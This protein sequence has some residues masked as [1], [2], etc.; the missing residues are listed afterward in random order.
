VKVIF[1]SKNFLVQTL[2][3]V[4]E[5]RPHISRE[6]GGH[7]IISPKVKVADRQHLTARQAIE[8][9]RLTVVVGEAMTTTMN[10]LGIDI[11]RINY[12][13][14]GNW[15]VLK[16]EGAFLHIHLYGRAKSARTQIYGEALSFPKP[17]TGFY[18]N[19]EAFSDE[20]IADLK[21]EIESLS[22]LAKYSDTAWRLE[23]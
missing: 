20:D 14:N 9:M 23:Q 3:G 6:D 21:G 17:D 5:N 8:L 4:N 16:P 10:R 12:Q 18:N 15:S 7:I 19:S 1:E 11:G 22:K 13:D 2:T